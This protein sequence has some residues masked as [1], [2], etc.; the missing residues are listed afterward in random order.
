LHDKEGD[1]KI[2]LRHTKNVFPEKQETQ[3][4][5]AYESSCSWRNWNGWNG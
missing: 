5:N 2:I 4:I 1:L 3:I